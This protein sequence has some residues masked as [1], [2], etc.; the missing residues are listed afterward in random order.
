[1]TSM[2]TLKLVCVGAALVLFGCG[3]SGEKKAASDE[4]TDSSSARAEAAV[5]YHP[6]AIGSTLTRQGFRV[7]AD[8][9]VPSQHSGR[10]AS[11]VVYQ[12]AD[13]AEGGVLY[14]ERPDG[15]GLEDAVW[16]WYFSETAPDS[17]QVE[18]INGDGLWDIRVFAKGGKTIDLIQRQS[19]T[20]MGPPL[21]TAV[22]VDGAASSPP[23]Q[24]KCF[25]GNGTTVWTVPSSD[26]YVEFLNP[27]RAPVTEIDIRLG[28]R[29][30]PDKLEVFAGKSK[31]QTIDLAAT[32][33]EQRFKLDAAVQN[34]ASI[35]FQVKAGTEISEMEIR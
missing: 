21:G 9:R 14:V 27:L 35:R 23:D 3:K 13:G 6:S 31:V 19:F 24:W 25:D 17:A 22:A 16:H 32:S 12:S 20:L 4:A 34:A 10:T 1:M 18:E 33:D 29:H 11:A 7:V 30:R 5:V 26:P 28:E 15:G 8:R 2:R